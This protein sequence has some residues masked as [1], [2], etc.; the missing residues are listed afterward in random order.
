MR[1]PD[2]SG[3]GVRDGFI[4]SRQS[5]ERDPARLEKAFGCCARGTVLLFV[6][7]ARHPAPADD[8]NKGDRI[9][10]RIYKGQERIDGVS[11]A[12]VLHVDDRNAPRCQIMTCSSSDRPSLA[13]CNVVPVF[14]EASGERI[15]EWLQNGVRNAEEMGRAGA[16]ESRQHLCAGDGHF[17]ASAR[18]KTASSDRRFAAAASAH[19]FISRALAAC[20]MAG[21]AARR[22]WF[23]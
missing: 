23:A 11:Q 6:P 20:C 5:S 16:L 21:N 8:E 10:F 13:D 3:T 9:D 22:R 7:E 15:T 14:A 18:D 19:L 2:C 17:G 4:V 12:R 1:L